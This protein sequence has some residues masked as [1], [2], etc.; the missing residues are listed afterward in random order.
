MSTPET[1]DAPD[2]VTVMATDDPSL[3]PVLQSL[4]EA[5]GIRCVIANQVAQDVIGMGRLVTGFNP[6]IGPALLQVAPEDLDAARELIAH[7]ISAS[8]GDIDSEAVL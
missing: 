2:L 1:N 4:L 3:F 5:E 8:E 6:V 7:H